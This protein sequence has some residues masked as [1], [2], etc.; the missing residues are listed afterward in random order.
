MKPNLF[1]TRTGGYLFNCDG[2]NQVPDGGKTL[3]VPFDGP[4]P[5]VVM[6]ESKRDKTW[7]PGY[8]HSAV[9]KST[10]KASKVGK[11]FE[12]DSTKAPALSGDLS[13]TIFG[14]GPGELHVYPAQ[15]L[16][17]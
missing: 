2:W 9:A 10:G 6:D 13:K 3:V 15:P 4:S 8:P 12:P 5:F 17:K 16:P 1:A 7:S 14:Y 11:C